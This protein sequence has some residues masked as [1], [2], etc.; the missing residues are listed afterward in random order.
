VLRLRVSGAAPAALG[1]R[2]ALGDAVL[3]LW[4]VNPDDDGL[5][6]GDVLRVTGLRA[7]RCADLG[8]GRVL[9]L[10]ATKMTRRAR[11]E[12]GRRAPVF[13]GGAAALGLAMGKGRRTRRSAAARL[14]WPA[15]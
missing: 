2:G 6:E 11:G 14:R 3:R 12:A 15:C 10:D 9:Q 13:A 8:F 1:R 5:R 7:L 4:R